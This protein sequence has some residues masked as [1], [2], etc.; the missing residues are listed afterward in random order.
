ML[1]ILLPVMITNTAG[2]TGYSMEIP[3]RLYKVE[4]LRNS[5]GG[6]NT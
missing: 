6:F 1:V 2:D 4:E 3:G 5:S